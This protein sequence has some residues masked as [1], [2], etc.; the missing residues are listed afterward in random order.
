MGSN[1]KEITGVFIAFVYCLLRIFARLNTYPDMNQAAPT[2]TDK[3]IKNNRTGCIFKVS[4]CQ[5]IGFNISTLR[6][7]NM[8]IAKIDKEIKKI[9]SITKFLGP[10]M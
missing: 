7:P 4:N 8:V 2:A 9:K 3:Y 10:L 6:N 5:S 1:W